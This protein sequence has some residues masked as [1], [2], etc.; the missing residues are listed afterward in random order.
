[1]KGCQ[2]LIKSLIT[3]RAK[4]FNPCGAGTGMFWD[5]YI[6]TMAVDALAPC[7]A[8]S[9]AAMGLTMQDRR[10]LVFHKEGL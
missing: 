1:M 4:D 7:V 6:N 5:N 10:V 9:S 3:Y 2:V 8:R